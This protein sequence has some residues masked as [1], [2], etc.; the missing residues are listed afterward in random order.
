MEYSAHLPSID[1]SGKRFLLTDL[2]SYGATAA[3]LDYTF[4]CANDHLPCSLPWLDDPTAL[5]TV[6]EASE[7]MTMAT[8]VSIPVVRGPI[9]T[10][11][12]LAAVD[13]LSG[14]RLWLWGVGARLIGA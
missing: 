11:R 1:F 6:I 4:L 3:E 8:I 14:D 7:R 10:A 9:V 2:R 13:I 12:T 5:A